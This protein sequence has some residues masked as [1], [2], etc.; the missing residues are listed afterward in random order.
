MHQLWTTPGYGSVLAEAALLWVGEPYARVEIAESDEA[1]WERLRQVNPLKQLP[2]LVLD[3]GPVLTES[4]AIMLWAG[5]RKPGSGL[6]PTATAPERARFLRFLVLLVGAVYPT[7]TYGDVP[8]KWVPESARD[9]LRNSTD[10]RR[11]ML[12]RVMEQE[13]QAPFF[14]GA[15]PCAIDLY[16]CVMT[17]W[18]PN[19]PWFAAE[20]P[21]LF[22]IAERMDADP[23]FAALWEANFSGPIAND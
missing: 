10:E 6:V 13:A 3:D 16:L 20:C 23:R 17:R 5:D 18:R 8:T 22:A 19:R 12:F 1:G 2:T 9:A 14:L 15:R 4:A 21:Q 11:K 7:F